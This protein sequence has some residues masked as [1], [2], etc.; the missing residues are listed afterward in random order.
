[1]YLDPARVGCLSREATETA[2]AGS[3]LD[4]EERMGRADPRG[5]GPQDVDRVWEDSGQDMCCGPCGENRRL[6]S[7]PGGESPGER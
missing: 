1:M 5:R 7:H 6:V 3:G 2:T 4:P